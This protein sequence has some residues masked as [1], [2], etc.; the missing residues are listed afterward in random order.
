AWSAATVADSTAAETSSECIESGAIAPVSTA[1]AATISAC[2]CV[3][4]VPLAKVTMY[5]T[6]GPEGGALVVVGATVVVP[7][8]VVAPDDVD[9]LVV[10]APD[11]VLG[12]VVVAPAV[13]ASVVNHA[14]LVE[15]VVALGPLL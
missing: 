12:A 10:V 8:V 13:E 3:C 9:G 7:V 2:C 14:V 6:N 5:G 11:G 15:S 4:E 1:P